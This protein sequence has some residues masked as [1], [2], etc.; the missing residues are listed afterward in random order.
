MEWR[1]ILRVWFSSCLLTER[2]LDLCIMATQF[3]NTL[4]FISTEMWPSDISRFLSPAA[5]DVVASG[6]ALLH[7]AVQVGANNCV[8][9]QSA[10]L[11]S[12]ASA[13]AQQSTSFKLAEVVKM[14][15]NPAHFQAVSEVAFTHLL[16]G[17]YRN[18]ILH[19]YVP[20]AL[21]A[22]SLHSNTSCDKGGGVAK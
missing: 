22:L 6:L 3:S 11:H 20:E 7:S 13:A 15:L 16:L 19:L 4:Q 8:Y 10:A 21:L 1:Y 17:H 9:P 18:Q 5:G 12:G 2:S 14:T